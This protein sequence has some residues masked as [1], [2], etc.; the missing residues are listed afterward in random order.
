MEEGGDLE[1]K[2]IGE[3]QKEWSTGNVLQGQ[4]ASYKTVTV[5]S[6]TTHNYH[7][8]KTMT[9]ERFLTI[10]RQ[11]HIILECWSHGPSESLSISYDFNPHLPLSVPACLPNGSIEVYLSMDI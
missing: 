3:D 11:E 2:Q 5:G 7:I 6:T 8:L 1:E 4:Y 9:E 10:I